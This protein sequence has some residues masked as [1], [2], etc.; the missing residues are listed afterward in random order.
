MD[1][2]WGADVAQLR[3]LAR[4]FQRDAQSLSDTR[5]QL[6]ALLSTNLAWLGPSAGRFRAEW[7]GSTG[8]GLA[9]AASALEQAGDQLVR[10]AASQ[11]R[12]SDSGSGSAG[13]G[14]G[15]PA[16][17]P[18]PGA[19]NVPSADAYLAMTA[20]ERDAWLRSASDAQV[21]ALYE[22]LTASG[23]QP[24]SPGYG[25]VVSE[26]WTRV[27][28][29]DAGIDYRSWDPTQGA[30]ANRGNI[31][32][33]YSYYSQLF[34]DNPDLQWAGMAAMIGPSFAAGFL[35]LAM[36][37]DIAQT[38]GAA[39][40]VLPPGV[41]DMLEIVSA[42]S[43][44]ELAFYETTFLEMQK[45][46]F[47]DQARMHAAY[48]HGGMN[49]ITRLHESGEINR[50]T[51]DAW[52]DIDSGDPERL[53]A[54]NTELLRREQL[55]IIADDYGA[56]TDRP[57]TG[58]AM[59]YMMTLVGEASIPGTQTYAQFD[60]LKVT[61]ETPGPERLGLPF[62]P[63]SVDNPVQG[64]IVTT[65]PLPGGNIAD[66]GERWAYVTADTLPAYQELL[67]SDPDRAAAIVGSDVSDRIDDYRLTNP[68]RVGRIVERLTEWDVEVNQ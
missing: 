6:G 19:P 52:S 60:P 38:V 62:T 48:T 15:G 7:S 10:N 9:R 56:M 30:Q 31:E 12:T 39:G 27:A 37:R 8:P 25:D 22:S 17:A 58:P 63:F 40:T 53:A 64:E 13:G 32:A 34:L 41:G 26:H 59:T 11:E 42:M 65:T 66:T 67:A 45:E 49:E 28:A 33:V 43:D 29:G 46:I 36:M 20:A 2:L 14:G 54:G 50:R 5:S 47:E 44:A 51:L 24:G 55:D 4:S 68:D 21:A 1:Q 35:D 23:A 16:G 18:G 57:V 3:A 61:I